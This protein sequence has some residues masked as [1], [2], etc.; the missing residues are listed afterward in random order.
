MGIIPWSVQRCS[1]GSRWC[2][3][4]ETIF[5]FL[6]QSLSL[7]LYVN[8][9]FFPPRSLE[10]WKTPKGAPAGSP[11]DSLLSRMPF[12]SLGLLSTNGLESQKFLLGK[13][14]WCQQGVLIFD[15][16]QLFTNLLIA[17][18]S[19]KLDETSSLLWSLNRFGKPKKVDAASCL[20]W[21]IWRPAHW[22]R[23]AVVLGASS[24]TQDE[25]S[26]IKSIETMGLS[27]SVYLSYLVFARRFI[28][29]QA[30]K[31]AH[32]RPGATG[33][34]RTWFSWEKQ[35]TRHPAWFPKSEGSIGGWRPKRSKK[36]F[37]E[38]KLAFKQALPN[39]QAL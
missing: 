37:V 32:P 25:S 18:F 3:L 5:F 4:E 27:W 29:Q 20:P 2:S 28:Y 15:G 22:R 9:N 10:T 21:R 24:K 12:R 23:G 19:F 33:P 26:R 36:T 14:G 1:K 16:F 17:W 7:S 38:P 34:L 11:F 30:S 39:I 13:S 35:A 31:L 8:E 6:F